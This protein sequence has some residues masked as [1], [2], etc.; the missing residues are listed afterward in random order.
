MIFY[1]S[2]TGNSLRVARSLAKPDNAMLYNM[3]T[4]I[5]NLVSFEEIAVIG[6]VFPVYAWGMPKLV[7]QFIASLPIIE[8][9]TYVFAVFTCGDDVAYTDYLL[10]KALTTRGWHL[11]SAFS[12]QMRN[13]YVCLP[14]FDVDTESVVAAKEVKLKQRI[15]HIQSAI[16]QKRSFREEEL[17][18]GSVPWV[19]HRILR[20]IFN[21]FLTSDKH[22]K[23]DSLVCSH[24][25]R[26]VK[27]CPLSNITFNQDN[28]P[29]WNGHCTQC[30]RC[31][32]ACPHHAISYGLFTRRKGQVKLFV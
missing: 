14:G 7:E 29:T 25:Q 27:E 28:C 5:S 16:K 18:R 31:Y 4:P 12:V 15:A 30:L 20:P 2:G 21:R 19:K 11:N 9:S 3:A 6:F 23:V 24:C 1:F 22:F 13:T 10:K 8:Q 26:C 32:H 17:V